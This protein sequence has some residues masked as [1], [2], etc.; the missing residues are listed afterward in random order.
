MKA[1]MHFLPEGKGGRKSNLVINRAIRNGV[2]WANT[3]TVGPNAWS[4]GLGFGEDVT[5][6]VPGCTYEVSIHFLSPEASSFFNIGDDLQYCEGQRVI[7]RGPIM[8]R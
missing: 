2:V 7:A 6:V 3:Q 4:I 1:L 8:E 5:E